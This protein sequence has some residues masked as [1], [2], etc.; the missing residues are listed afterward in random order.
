MLTWMRRMGK[1]PMVCTGCELADFMEAD[2]AIA[3]SFRRIVIALNV[4][5]CKSDHN[6]PCR[7]NNMKSVN[8][9][10]RSHRLK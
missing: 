1:L 8:Y 4:I 3:W 5:P 10:D 9:H 6:E 2:C 7:H